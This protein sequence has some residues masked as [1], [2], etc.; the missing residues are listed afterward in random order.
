MANL[1]EQPL[2]GVLSI[3]LLSLDDLDFY[4][5]DDPLFMALGDWHGLWL[6]IFVGF[7]VFRVLSGGFVIKDISVG[8]Y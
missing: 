8:H 6:N 1:N 3:H 7:R 5:M 4:R 2:A